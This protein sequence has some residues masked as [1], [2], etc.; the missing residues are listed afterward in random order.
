MKVH[1]KGI[2]QLYEPQDEGSHARSDDPDWNESV[3]LL[4]WDETQSVYA[5]F[6][7]GHEANRPPNGLAAVWINIWTPGLYYKNYVYP[8]MQAGDE[9]A[10]GLGAGRLCRYACERGRHHWTIEDGPVSVDVVMEDF[11][12]G[13]GFWPSLGQT[14]SKDIAK[15]HIEASGSVSG[16]IRLRD[17]AFIVKGALAFRDH[18]WGVRRWEKARAHRW[19]PALFGSDLTL[20]AITWYGADHTLTSYGF[21]VKAGEIYVPQTIDFVSYSET[22]AITHRGGRLVLTMPS[23]EIFD[24]EYQGVAPAGVSDHHGYP[25]ADL[26]CRTVLNSGERVGVGLVQA[27][28]NTM[29]GTDFPPAEALVYGKRDNGF[30]TL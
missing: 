12:Q 25:A 10:A 8:H 27:G 20:Q 28:F 15:N 2:I 17:R 13:F 22:D 9:F 7:L 16:T 4:L 26:P 18:S 24:C 6:R 3:V 30:F 19:A 21:V 1:G 23:G 11:H 5:D 14:L 29:G